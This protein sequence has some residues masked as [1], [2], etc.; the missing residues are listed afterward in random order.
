MAQGRDLF[1]GDVE[2]ATDA[3]LAVD[4]FA[5]VLGGHASAKP[6]GALALDAADAVWIVHMKPQKKRRIAA[7]LTKYEPNLVDLG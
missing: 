3:T 5:A 4:E 6:D 7:D 1:I 2:A